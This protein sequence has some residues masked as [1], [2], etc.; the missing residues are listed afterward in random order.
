MDLS[1]IHLNFLLADVSRLMRR[2]FEQRLTDSP[3]TFAQVR[4]LIYATRNEGLRQI[5]LAEMLE[6]QPITLAR[7]VDQ[8]VEAELV[9]RRADPADR[10]A[11]QVYPTPAAQAHVEAIE[12]LA[13]D[14]R[15]EATAGLSKAQADAV[16]AALEIMRN[17][18]VAR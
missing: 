15:R 17:N 2:A 8:L 6:V 5:E 3:L 1:Q 7:L 9:E 12:S 18:L 16:T 13:A 4:V 11:Y 14:I 10:R